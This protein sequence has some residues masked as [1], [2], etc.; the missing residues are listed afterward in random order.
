[1]GENQVPG[2]HFVNFV[3]VDLRIA[4][5]NAHL[6]FTRLKPLVYVMCAEKIILVQL[7]KATTTNAS[8]FIVV[9]LIILN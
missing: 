1:M 3:I 6:F 5:Y 8:T 9:T 4:A 2:Y 7:N